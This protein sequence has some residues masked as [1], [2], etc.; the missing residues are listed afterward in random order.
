MEIDDLLESEID[1]PDMVRALQENGMD[2]DYNSLVDYAFRY[3]LEEAFD[4]D[5]SKYSGKFGIY[6]NG[7]DTHMYILD[8]IRDEYRRKYGEQLAELEAYMNMEFE[9]VPF[10]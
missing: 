9:E 2:I 6:V 5:A 3:K 1:V 8:S 7:I 4:Y 10:M